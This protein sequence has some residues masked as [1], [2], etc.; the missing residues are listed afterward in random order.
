MKFVPT[1]N[2]IGQFSKRQGELICADQ[3]RKDY[4]EACRAQHCSRTGVTVLF[5]VHMLIGLF[6]ALS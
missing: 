3:C 1:R 2:L 4:G 6:M 5:V